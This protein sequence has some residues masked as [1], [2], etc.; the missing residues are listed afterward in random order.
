MK[1]ADDTLEDVIARLRRIEGQIGGVIRMVESER[2]CRDVVRQISAAS[3]AL[4]QV[5]FKI[6]ASGLRLC[7]SDARAAKKAGYTEDELEKLFLQ[8]S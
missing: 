1:L 8:L 4:D 3:K 7:V 6:L 5:G 2:E